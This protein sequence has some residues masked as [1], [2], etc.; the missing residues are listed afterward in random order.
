MLDQLEP[1]SD[2]VSSL[3]RHEF[4]GVLSLV[5]YP[6]PVV[7]ALEITVDQLRLIKR[8]GLEVDVDLISP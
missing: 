4:D 5:V 8:L 6:G 2:A 1:R 3:T 7:P